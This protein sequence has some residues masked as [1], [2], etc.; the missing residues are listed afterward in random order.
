M[1]SEKAEV[2]PLTEPGNC[3]PKLREAGIGFF[4]DFGNLVQ[5]R[6]A[7][8]P[9]PLDGSIKVNQVFGGRLDRGDG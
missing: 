9:L 7:V 1:H 2:M 8:N 6:F 4:N 5:T 3:K